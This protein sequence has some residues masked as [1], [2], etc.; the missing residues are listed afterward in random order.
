MLFILTCTSPW[1]SLG[2]GI[3]CCMHPARLSVRPSVCPSGS[4]RNFKF[5]GDITLDTSN[6]GSANFRSKVKG[7]WERNVNFFLCVYLR[8]KHTDLHQTKT[9]TIPGQFRTYRRI[10]FSCGNGNFKKYFSACLSHTEMHNFSI[11]V[12]F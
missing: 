1:P 4:H 12:C 8:E 2:C 9:R 11:F 7:H 5:G 10:H 3:K 6:C